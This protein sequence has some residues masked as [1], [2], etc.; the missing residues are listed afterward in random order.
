MEL[1]TEVVEGTAP[2]LVQGII[3][4]PSRWYRTLYPTS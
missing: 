3:S 4:R 2:Y 1:M